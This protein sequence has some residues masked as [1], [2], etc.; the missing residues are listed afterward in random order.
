MNATEQTRSTRQVE[1]LRESVMVP[2]DELRE[3]LRQLRQ[4]HDVSSIEAELT[5]LESALDA[6]AALLYHPV[7]PT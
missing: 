3:S 6:L 1:H 5:A 4:A 7:D 2:L